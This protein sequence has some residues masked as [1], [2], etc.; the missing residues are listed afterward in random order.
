MIIVGAG[1]AGL[2][3]GHVFPGATIIERSPQRDISAHRAL[4]RFRGDAI[5]NITGI[6]FRKVQV[7]KAVWHNDTLLSQ[8]SIPA[9]NHYAL[10]T[11]GRAHDRSI[12]N[13]ES[14]ER[15]IAPDDLYGR[16][17]ANVSH[18]IMWDTDIGALGVVGNDVVISTAPMPENIRNALGKS[19][20]IDLP[21]L[22][23][24]ARS[25]IN[26][27][28]WH[29]PGVEV[30][31][32]IYVASPETNVY[33][34]SITGSTLIVESMVAPGMSMTLE[35]VLAMFG[36]ESLHDAAEYLGST[37]QSYGKIAP[38]DERLRKELIHRLS[39]EHRLYSVGR[40][41]TW[42]N[43]LLDDVVH[44]LRVVK[45]LIEQDDVYASR[46]RSL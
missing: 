29:L 13:L 41:A 46:L 19:V 36:L 1:L 8:T 33:R 42:R 18:R 4:M 12:W 35:L 24:F 32:T 38:I 45:E 17:L 10:K 28:R 37:E 30:Y 25:P 27:M 40:F 5:S 20:Q 34:A 7:H 26:V 6:P 3:A 9:A 31:Q 43:I 44:D 11:A 22:N 14:V 21:G 23:A 15:W 39:T 2:I 16:M